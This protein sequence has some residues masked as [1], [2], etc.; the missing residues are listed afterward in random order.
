MFSR[1]LFI[2]L[3]FASFATNVL[4]QDGNRAFSDYQFSSERVAAASKKYDDTLRNAFRKKG[5]AWPPVEIYLRAF[6]SQNE[7]ELWARNEE[8]A[9][10]Q[11]VKTYRVCA[12][13]GTLGPKRRQGDKQVPEGFYFID[14]FNPRSDYHLSMLLNYPNYADQMQGHDK[15]GGDIYIHGGCLTVGCLPMNND[16][17]CEIYM[18]CLHAKINGQEYIP[19]HIYPTRLTARGVNYLASEYHGQERQQQFWASLRNEYEYF[20]KNHK[21][22]PVMYSREGTYIN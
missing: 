4:A 7:M 17:I 11:K 3:V 16:G 20:E 2:C 15:L 21:L 13:S 9:E 18:A 22:L 19:V 12:I 5:L 8:D 14:D 10:F 6:K 1:V